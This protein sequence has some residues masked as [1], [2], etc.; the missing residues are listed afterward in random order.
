MAKPVLVPINGYYERLGERPVSDAT[1]KLIRSSIWQ[2]S[3]SPE[4]AGEYPPNNQLYMPDND[5]PALPQISPWWG[6]LL[7]GASLIISLLLLLERIL[8]SAGN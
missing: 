8:T 1:W 7:G 5:W 2:D 4:A 3:Y 6:V